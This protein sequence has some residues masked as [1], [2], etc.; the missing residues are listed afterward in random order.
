[1]K[2]Y[3]Q[4][5]KVIDFVAAAAIASG[6]VVRVGQ[7][8]GVSVSDVAI[9]ETGQAHI[10]GVFAVP[11]VSGAVIARGESL[12]WDAS[13]A[14]FDDNAAVPASGDVQ[15]APAVAF[16]A[17]GNGVLTIAVRFTGVPGTVTA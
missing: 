11:K 8:L 2:N 6:Q 14:A 1:M 10:E 16:E 5:G 4:P 15:G 7:I 17:A 3:I 12:S 13:A 9:G